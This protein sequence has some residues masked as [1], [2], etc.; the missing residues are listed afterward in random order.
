MVVATVTLQFLQGISDSHETAREF[1]AESSHKLG[2]LQKVVAAD[3]DLSPS[4]LSRKFAQS[5]GDTSRFTL[6]DAEK[7]MA[8][9]GD[10]DII[11]YWIE[12]Y[13]QPKRDETQQLKA[14]IERL[15]GLLK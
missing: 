4:Q 9:T 6:D 15:Q 11:F 2:K 1:I 5:P 14:E 10:H 3:M 12:K 8:A 7:Y 13:L